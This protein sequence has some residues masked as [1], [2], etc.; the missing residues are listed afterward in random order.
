MFDELRR[1]FREL[2]HGN[3]PPEARRE[4]LHMMKESLVHARLS[5]DELRTAL[6]ETRQRLRSERGELETVLRRKGLA[7]G[8]GDS[9]TV[10]IA[11]RFEAQH[12]RRLEVLEKKEAAQASELALVERE[13]EEMTEQF[14]AA[15]GGSPGPREGTAFD[16]EESD[17]A[18]RELERELD[19][20][21]RAQRK[22]AVEA[23]AEA[24]LAD[25]KRRMGKQ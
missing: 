5:L 15:G 11:E 19:T 24:R 8:I 25:L 9:E 13:V 18:R 7:Q 22:A 2:V 10:T 6:E 21:G 17:D 16:T 4:F 23:E 3:V 14:R 12:T 20:I 1:A